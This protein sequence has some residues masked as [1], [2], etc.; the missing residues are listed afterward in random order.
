ML[1]KKLFGQSAIYGIASILVNGSG[2]LLLPLYT[3]SLNPHDYG[4][5]STTGILSM[6]YTYLLGFGLS[7]S[8][9]R[10]YF[11]LKSSGKWK[12]FVGTASIF[13][14]TVGLIITSALFLFGKPVLDHIFKSVRFDPYLKYGIWI[15]YLGIFSFIP[16]AL[17]QVQAKPLLYRILTTISF[18]FLTLFMVYFV[19]IEDQGAIG[20]LK[21]QLSSGLIMASIYFIFMLREGGILFNFKYLK[22]SLAYGLP[23]MVYLIFGVIV[24]MSSKYYIEKYTTLSDLGIY[25][26]AQ[27]YTSIMLLVIS[28]INLAWI[29][30]FYE[31]AKKEIGKE[32]FVQFGSLFL[33]G[34]I[35]MALGLSLFSKEVLFLFASSKYEGAYSVVPLIA[36]AYVFGNG[37]W[38]LII[39]PITYVK[40]TIFLPVLT[41]ITGCFSM[42]LNILFVPKLGIYGAALALLISYLI[43]TFLGLLIVHRYYPIKYNYSKI[44]LILFTAILFYF[45]SFLIP[46]DNTFLIITLKFIIIALFIFTLFLLKIF[47]LYQVKGY[48]LQIFGSR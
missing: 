35:T 18:L 5:I 3:R 20:A 41:I 32:P 26:L 13:I 7:S 9:S 39:N 22:I 25:N 29:P 27:Q 21:A 31:E 45:S 12:S 15:G 16:L 40:K 23:I 48:L 43:L 46:I 6:L 36:L 1:A 10:Y 28:A 44:G 17:F 37:F 30:I 14:I 38:I 2:F 19:V 42:L 4:I 33:T 34:V 47:S 24:E 11:D 8:I